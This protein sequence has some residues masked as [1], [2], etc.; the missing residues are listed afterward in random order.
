MTD[1][2]TRAILA[3]LRNRES[4]D[5]DP[6]DIYYCYRLLLGRHADVQGW[7]SWKEFI[8]SPRPVM[9]T[10]AGFMSSPEFVAKHSSSRTRVVEN[11]GM[12][13][14]VDPE[15]DAVGK[16]IASGEVY[17]PDVT[18]AIKGLLRPDSVFLDIGANA[19]WFSLLAARIAT[20]GRVIAI[21]PNPGNVALLHQSLLENHLSNV[22]VYHVAASQADRTLEIRSVQSNGYVAAA[23]EAR[24]GVTY[25]QGVRLDTLLAGEPRIDVIKMDIE[26]HEMSALLGMTGL[27]STHRPVILTEFHPKNLKELGGI[28]P[29][30]YL[31]MLESL[32]W[33][34]A[35]IEPDGSSA[36]AGSAEIMQRWL[37]QGGH[38]DP[39][40]EH[41]LDLLARPANPAAKRHS[42]R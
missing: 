26:G 30:T 31:E 41:H 38:T 16:V 7:H 14:A 10:V 1:L 32:G 15:D 35:V 20:C 21:E 18:A 33:I 5:T 29:L 24:A 11:S 40:G 13:F 12:R 34:L 3:I 37:S 28:E 23:T 27:L 17:E 22:V 9:Q 4:P 8:R 39:I 2:I 25:A 6:L 42:A 19:G 36:D